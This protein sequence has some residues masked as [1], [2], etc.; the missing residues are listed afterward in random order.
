MAKARNAFIW[1]VVRL[2]KWSNIKRSNSQYQKINNIA[3]FKN[4]FKIGLRNLWKQKMYSTINVIGLS[5]AIGCCL[6]AFKFIEMNFVRDDFHKNGD[7]IYLSTHTA[8]MDGGLNKYGFMSV[9]IS[10][11]MAEDYPAIK[12]VVRYSRRSV[13]VEMGDR[14]FATSA[15]FVDT[16]YFNVFSFLLKYG[17]K[18]LLKEPGNI[19][20]STPTSIRYFGDEYPIGKT[21]TMEFNG[22]RHDFVVAGVLEPTPQNSSMR[23]NILVNF[24]LV[25][26]GKA[27][28]SMKSHVFVQA[29]EGT[30]IKAL[31][32][33]LNVLSSV[34]QGYQLDRK[35]DEIG[36]QPLTTMAR[37]SDTVIEGLGSQIPM[38]PM[39]LIASI[40]LFMLILSTFNYVNI[41]TLMATKRMKEIGVRKVIGGRRGQLIVQFLTENLILCLIS[42]FIGCL[43]GAVFFLPEFNKL[44]GNSITLDL[45]NHRN[46]WLFLAALLFFITMVSGAYPAFYISKFKPVTIFRGNL[47]TGKKRRFISVLLTFQFVLAIVTIVAGIMFVRTNQVNES[48]SWGYDKNDK[49]VLNIPNNKYYSLLKN[50]LIQQSGV[51]EI[52]GSKGIVGEWNCPRKVILNNET[53]SVKLIEGDL[54]YAELLQLKLSEGRYFQEDL[55]SDETSSVLINQTFIDRFGL[56]NP[57]EASITIE[58]NAVQIVGV[59]ED[60]HFHEFSDAIGPA[61]VKAIPD[62]LMTHM[63]IQVQKGTALAMQA[64]IEKTWD[65]VIVDHDYESMLQSEVFEFHF[66]DVRGI[67]NVMLFTASLAVILSAMGLFGLVSLSITSHI[68]D[69]G[70]KKILGAT[71]I[72]IGKE[73]YKK[74]I[75]IMGV[76]IVLG[77][78]LAIVIINKLLDSAYG[79]HESIG[80]LT[81]LLAA[82]ILIVIAWLT[83][84]SQVMKVQ[85][86]NPAETLRVE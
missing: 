52:A 27:P 72:Q 16:N 78:G 84:K 64:A 67:S 25:R 24:D 71:G 30:D 69:F 8:F 17:E 68:K 29:V 85:R 34:Q 53:I 55:K 21:I 40:G 57:L 12:N 75:L 43:L 11:L 49:V 81:L 70:I 63:T 37:N 32:S 62:S 60:F 82:L 66:E 2:F 50:E 7:D 1:D 9:S 6:V 22:E 44:S 83:I 13:S 58:G 26:K 51:V 10:D 41:A 79:Y 20:I 48:R 61:V 38:E 23:P 39:V 80:I 28:E 18:Y 31:T 14:V 47:K 42:I 74:F 56:E 4:Y 76:A 33:N 35:Y 3:V 46:L 73:V 36:L 5:M 15:C 19:A 59:L 45:L 86:M 77:S 54:N 65:D